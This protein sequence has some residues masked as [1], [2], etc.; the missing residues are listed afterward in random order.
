LGKLHK[1]IERTSSLSDPI[2]WFFRP[3]GGR[4]QVP[5]QNSEAI[6]NPDA[7]ADTETEDVGPAFPQ[8]VNQL[9]L[10]PLA[11]SLIQKDIMVLQ[12]CGTI[13]LKIKSNLVLLCQFFGDLDRCIQDVSQRRLPMVSKMVQL[14]RWNQKRLD[15][16]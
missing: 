10:I 15:M 13:L 6:S 7:R 14:K 8:L 16:S 11:W 12:D 1:D 9:R 3:T 4:G 2:K 5:G